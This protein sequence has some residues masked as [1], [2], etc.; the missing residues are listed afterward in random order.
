MATDSYNPCLKYI[1]MVILLLQTVQTHFTT[2]CLHTIC[3]TWTKHFHGLCL[4]YTNII[5]HNVKSDQPSSCIYCIVLKHHDYL[6]I[7]W[8]SL[9]TLKQKQIV[10]GN[11]TAILCLQFA[12]CVFI[13]FRDIVNSLNAHFKEFMEIS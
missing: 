10:T 5:G 8:F 2:V 1:I 11:T 13:R 3:V 9:F 7:L 6:G 4:T 12:L